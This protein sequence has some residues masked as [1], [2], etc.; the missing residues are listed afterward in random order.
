MECLFLVVFFC[1]HL[2]YRIPTTPTSSLNCAIY[3][4]CILFKPISNNYLTT[5]DDP[6]KLCVQ[7]LLTMSHTLIVASLLPV[8]NRV[9][10]LSKVMLTIWA[11]WIAWWK[12][13]VYNILHIVFKLFWY[14]HAGLSLR[15]HSRKLTGSETFFFLVQKA[16]RP[17]LK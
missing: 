6:V 1:F 10:L 8:A 5:P 15:W 17:A 14:I 11:L 7:Y 4:H 3:I 9:L 13:K 16:Y 12:T 2:H